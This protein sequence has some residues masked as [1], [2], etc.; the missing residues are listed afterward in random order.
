MNPATV[1]ATDL[2]WSC[3]WRS[4]VPGVTAAIGAAGVALP[5]PLLLRAR[6]PPLY[7]GPLRRGEGRPEKPAGELAGMRAR[8][9]PGHG[10]PVIRPR[11]VLAEFAGMD[12]RK[13]RRWGYISL[14][15]L[16]IWVYKE[17]VNRPLQ[18]GESS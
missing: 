4:D 7:R 15:L 2:S 17:K 8:L 14:W 13:P 5:L 18:V 9:M 16:S 6:S 11:P 3:R 12:A 10:W 1:H